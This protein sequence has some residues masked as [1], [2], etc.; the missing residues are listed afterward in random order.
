MLSYK[1]KFVVFYYF[2]LPEMKRTILTEKLKCC[3]LCQKIGGSDPFSFVMLEQFPIIIEF[4]KLH[5]FYS[6]C[7]S[8]TYL[9]NNTHNHF[10]S[11]F[12]FPHNN[13]N[14]NNNNNKSLEIVKKTHRYLWPNMYFFIDIT[15]K[16]WNGGIN[17]GIYLLLWYYLLYRVS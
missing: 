7:H 5:I 1:I 12:H 2:Y 16:E 13:N 3:K 8:T 6:H 11:L 10:V 14:N 9:K 4:I 15:P 17:A